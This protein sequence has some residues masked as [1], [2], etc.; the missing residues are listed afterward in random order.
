MAAFE[1]AMECGADGIELDVHMTRDGHPVVIHDERLERT[2]TGKGYVKD[3]RL[4]ELKAFDAGRWFSPKFRGERIPTLREVFQRIRLDSRCIQIDVELKTDVFDYEGI[5]DSVWALV[6]EYGLKDNVIVSS[7]NHN[8]LS[9]LKRKYSQASIGLLYTG[10]L[11]E[12]WCYA[13]RMKAAALHP[14]HRGLPNFVVYESHRR[15]I[16]IH[17]WT[18][19]KASDMM[20]MRMMDVDA[21]ITDYPDVAISLF[22]RMR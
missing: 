2:T 18:V 17:P 4:E 11:D 20:R 8:T 21:I 3:Y 6:E 5:E 19:N 12:P 14:Q 7:F 1:A 16:C 9:R 22:R 10:D 15:G 13:K